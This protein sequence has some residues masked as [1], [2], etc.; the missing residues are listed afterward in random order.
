MYFYVGGTTPYNVHLQG[1]PMEEFRAL[2]V[3][4]KCR[5][6]FGFVCIILEIEMNIF[7]NNQL[8]FGKHIS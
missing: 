1:V 3:M 4:C 5:T 8:S 7:S 2:L 6:K